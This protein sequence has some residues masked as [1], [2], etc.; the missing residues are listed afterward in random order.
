[1]R[2]LRF[3]FQPRESRSWHPFIFGMAVAIV[4]S[5]IVVLLE[6]RWG[7]MVYL[8]STSLDA[9]LTRS[10]GLPPKYAQNVLIVGITD[11]DYQGLLFQQKSPLN[12]IGVQKLIEAV[13]Y[14]R[15]DVIGVDL[16]LSDSPGFPDCVKSELKKKMPHPPVIVW[17]ELTEEPHPAGSQ[18]I[19]LKD[20]AQSSQAKYRGVAV[21]PQDLDGAVRRYWHMVSVSTKK[22]EKRLEPTL[23]FQVFRRWVDIHPLKQEISEDAE[24]RIFNFAA[25]HY[26]FL[27][28]DAATVE[29]MSHSPPSEKFAHK[30][31]LIGGLFDAARDRYFTPVGEKFGVE[32]IAH[33]I[34]SE[35]TEGE[36]SEASWVWS[37]LVL[38]LPL[39]AGLL[40]LARNWHVRFPISTSV[41][42]VL[43]ISL[44][45]SWFVLHTWAYWLSFMPVLIGVV[46][47]EIS[48]E[49][50]E[51]R[52][53]ER[54]LHRVNR[55]LQEVKE[56][57]C[58]LNEELAASR[59]TAAQSSV[60]ISIEELTVV[61]RA[62][63]AQGQGG[64]P[65]SS[66]ALPPPE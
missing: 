4:I 32:L 48:D 5:A 64:S 16:D 38:E 65:S 61:M 50:R 30:I 49:I 66:P 11:S 52:E 21:F 58:R 46:V 18:Q 27:E 63:A 7:V 3:L 57:N 13:A 47:H 23:G 14:Q 9:Y 2:L 54:K 37:I 1:M 41:V 15:P 44:L 31:V 8:Q 45:I 36:V 60:Q 29:D 62:A 56:D 42:V 51:G 43:A 33:A 35:M 28:A 22:N 24:P 6:Q 59:Q 39:S 25:E 34:E 17:T 12:R 55:Q 26:A 53:A 10:L 20:T 19:T 40:L